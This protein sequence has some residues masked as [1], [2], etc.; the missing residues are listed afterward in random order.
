MVASA[1]AC[2]RPFHGSRICHSI[3]WPTPEQPI[4]FSFCGSRFEM[5]FFSMKSSSDRDFGSPGGGSLDADGSGL[6]GAG[7][8]VGGGGAAG[9]GFNEID[10]SG[11]A[12]PARQAIS[13]SKEMKPSRVKRA[14]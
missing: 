13:F 2:S 5:K 9:A 4:R 14:R 1:E 3:V 10:S 8:G 12:V 7:G 6:T 11:A